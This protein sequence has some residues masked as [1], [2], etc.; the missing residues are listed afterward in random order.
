MRWVA[1]EQVLHRRAIL[2][3]AAAS[4][5]AGSSPHAASSDC[6]RCSTC[7]ACCNTFSTVATYATAPGLSLLKICASGAVCWA[8]ATY[9]CDKVILHYSCALKQQGL[10]LKRQGCRSAKLCTTLRRQ[11]ACT[12]NGTHGPLQAVKHGATHVEAFPNVAVLFCFSIITF[13]LINVCLHLAL[14]RWCDKSSS[15]G[16]SVHRTCRGV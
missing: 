9:R 16:T 14:A 6:Q 2:N 5:S 7:C 3:S 12:Y 1:L 13:V 4:R 10:L 11:V 15:T 8:T